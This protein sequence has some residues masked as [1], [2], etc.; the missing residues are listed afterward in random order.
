M[1]FKAGECG[2]RKGRPKGSGGGRM[3]A[4]AGLDNMLAQA[5]DREFLVKALRK[6]MRKNPIQ[7]FKSVI[8]PLLPKEASLSVQ[9]DGVVLWRSLLGEEVR[10]EDVAGGVRMVGETVKKQLAAGEEGRSV[11]CPTGDNTCLSS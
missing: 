4:L 11:P 3:L 2:N 8:M 7:F 6:E 9:H 1:P 5:A 10:P